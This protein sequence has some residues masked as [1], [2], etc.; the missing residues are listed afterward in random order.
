VKKPRPWLGVAS[1][2]VVVLGVAG[3]YAAI[4]LTGHNPVRF[5]AWRSEGVVKIGGH[6]HCAAAAAS[7]NAVDVGPSERWA[8]CGSPHHYLCF[9]QKSTGAAWTPL[10]MTTSDCQSA[11]HVLRDSGL[12]G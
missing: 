6:L 2:V 7:P 10:S 12:T 4:A 8:V 9:H 3:A 5:F 1:G 11:F